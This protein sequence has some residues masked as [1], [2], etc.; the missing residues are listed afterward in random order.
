MSRTLLLEWMD[1]PIPAALPH[2]SFATYSEVKPDFSDDRFKEPLVDI[3]TRGVKGECF[4]AREDG[5]NAPYYRKVTLRP[6]KV[7]LRSGVVNRLANVNA[8]LA[9]LGV[10]VY[11]LDGY[12]PIECQ[13]AL[14]DF[15][16]ERARV[17]LPSPTEEQCLEFTKSF[18]ADPRR[19]EL[20]DPTSWTLHITGGA[21]D[22]TLIRKDNGQELYMGGIFDDSHE[23][24][25]P[26]YY[27]TA[28]QE[29]ASSYIEAKRNRRLLY[30][31][32]RELGFTNHHNEWWHFDYGTQLW[33]LKNASR[34][35][36]HSFYGPAELPA[37]YR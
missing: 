34:E 15:F 29:S 28:T 3:V 11:V 24:S 20:A 32:M 22:L 9:P 21:V 17:M 31:V 12:R 33:V 6:E 10:E 7:W 14:W 18:V 5:L 30:W 35:L 25:S 4:Y 1:R 8:L 36:V 2:P 13:Q 16:M 37:G 27:E 19:F 26:R 23:V